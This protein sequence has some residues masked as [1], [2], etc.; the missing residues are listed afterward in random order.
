MPDNFYSVTGKEWALKAIQERKIDKLVQELDISDFLARIVCSR[1]LDLIDSD[2]AE[3]WLEPRLKSELPSPFLLKDMSRA[4]KRIID[5]FKRNQKIAIFGD[6]DV[7]GATSSALLY[8]TFQMFGIEPIIYIPDRIKEGYGPNISALDKLKNEGIDLLITVDCGTTSFDEID[9]ANKINLDIIIIDHHNPE[10]KLPNAFAIVNPNRIDDS[11]GLGMLAAVGV[12][13]MLAGAVKNTLI[14]N[15]ILKDDNAANLT[16]VLD[17]VALGTICDVVPLIGPNRAL[18]KQGLKS[19]SRMNNLGIKTLFEISGIEDFP[20]V[21][22][23]GFVL[24]PKINAGG[25]VGQ[26]ELGAKL[27]TT[28]SSNDAKRISLQLDNYNEERKRLELEVF[29]EAKDMASQ[30]DNS[31]VL[32]LSG[33]NWHS[34]VIGIVASRIVEYYNKPTIIIAKNGNKSKGSARSVPGINIGQLITS[35]KQSGLLING[36]GHFMAGG[37]TI[38][39]Q[40]ISDFKVFLNNKVTNKNIEDSNYIRWIDLAVSVSGLNPELYSQ[41]Q[42]AEPY[43]SGNPEPRFIIQNASIFGSKIVGENHIS[44]SISDSTK[45]RING[46]AF[47]SVGTKLGNALLN[48]NYFHVIG[49]FK[50]SNWNGA[51]RVQIFIEDLIEL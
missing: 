44:C 32:V 42:R 31:K 8:R 40:K 5:A 35:A 22:H 43:G 30:D 13:F 41:L 28:D 15:N 47:R 26:S 29:V 45:A 39:E 34:G 14:K 24:G 37:I 21:Y 19:M 4:V 25:R 1:N 3:K 46:I 51:D 48:K 12:S 20:S 9:Y 11:S 16:K 6:Y 18:V 23:A 38:D 49:R 2:I 33:N 10:A 50:L 17:L 36:G 7:D 27:L